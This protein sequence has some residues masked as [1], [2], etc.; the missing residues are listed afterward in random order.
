MGV[1]LRAERF[2]ATHV[3]N[4]LGEEG[5]CANEVTVLGAHIVWTRFW[6]GGFAVLGSVLR[7]HLICKI[8]CNRK[9]ARSK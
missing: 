1:S 4:Y 5:Y 6:L 2:A 8:T 7:L 9:G 3:Y